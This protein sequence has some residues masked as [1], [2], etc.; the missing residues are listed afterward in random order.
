MD[1]IENDGFSSLLC[2]RLP[3]GIGRF[4]VQGLTFCTCV[5]SMVSSVSMPF[6]ACF[7]G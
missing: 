7:Y 5:V 4:L 3:E 1:P 6:K 2:D